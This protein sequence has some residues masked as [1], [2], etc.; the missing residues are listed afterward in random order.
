MLHEY[1]Y[2]PRGR[3]V[4]SATSPQGG[5]PLCFSD[6]SVASSRRPADWLRP[7]TNSPVGEPYMFV[8]AFG[9]TP[10]LPNPTAG[11]RSLNIGAVLN[12]S[13]VWPWRGDFTVDFF[14]QGF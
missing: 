14:W 6:F 9:E 1:Q 8:D 12:V 2:N 7:Q 4:G 11:I 5:Q 13:R 3:A 10:A